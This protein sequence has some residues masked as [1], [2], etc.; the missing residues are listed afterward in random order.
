MTN[1]LHS[2]MVSPQELAVASSLARNYV[3]KNSGATD[4]IATVLENFLQ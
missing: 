3:L 1:Q 2:F 4:K